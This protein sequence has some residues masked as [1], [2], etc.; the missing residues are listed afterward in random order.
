VVGSA[1]SF[2]N[3]LDVTHRLTIDTNVDRLLLQAVDQAGNLSQ[4]VE[5]RRQ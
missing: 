2:D 5:W 3:R 4:A 1:H